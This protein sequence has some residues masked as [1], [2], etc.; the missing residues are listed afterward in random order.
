MLDLT[1]K[2]IHQEIL[3]EEFSEYQKLLDN[4]EIELPPITLPCIP[5]LG[6]APSGSGQNKRLRTS[7]EK[8]ERERRWTP[9]LLAAAHTL[10]RKLQALK[11]RLCP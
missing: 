5:S 9:Q 2:P 3:D 6:P 11:A 4:M 7:R 1:N 10:Q 8:S